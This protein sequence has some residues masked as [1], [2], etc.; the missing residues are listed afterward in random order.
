MLAQSLF[1]SVASPI[2]D[3]A[4]GGRASGAERQAGFEALLDRERASTEGAA[5]LGPG[6]PLRPEVLPAVPDEGQATKAGDAGPQ[7]RPDVPDE[8]VVPKA[9]DWTGPQIR[10]DV[11]DEGREPKVIDW[12]GPQI[13]PRVPD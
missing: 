4:A 8:G 2:A 1:T 11:P 6:V 13:R 12:T 3:Q 9:L 7:V 5:G 10:P